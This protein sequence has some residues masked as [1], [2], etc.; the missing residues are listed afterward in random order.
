MKQD[1]VVFP[2]RTNPA[3]AA[4]GA[5]SAPLLVFFGHDSRE[6]TIRKR[7]A[8]FQAEGW[9]VRGFTFARSRVEDEGVPAHSLFWENVHLGQT[10]D[11]NYHRRLAALARAIPSI[12]REAEAIRSA[13]VIYARNLDMMAL[14]VTAKRLCRS[15]AKL[16]YEVLDVQRPLLRSG[17]AG[18]AVRA[19]ER[20]LL[21]QSDLLVVSAPEFV[22]RF[23]KPVQ[24]YSGPVHLLENKIS[25]AQLREAPQAWR[26]G[27]LAPPDDG[28]WIIGWSGVL[29]CA[30]SLQILERIAARMG[31]RVRVVMRGRL[32]EEDLPRDAFET[33]LR[34]QP[35]MSFGGSYRSPDDLATMYGGVHFN[36]SI[37][38]TD[39]GSNSDWLLPNRVYEG[40]FFGVPALARS[41]TASGRF[42]D[43][44]A[45]GHVLPEPL[46]DAVCDLLGRLTRHEY[47][48][49]RRKLL[50]RPESLFVDDGQVA[51]LLSRF[52]AQGAAT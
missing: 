10:Q 44:H 12:L 48:A 40:G 11:R 35:N 18:A 14:A 30:R 21:G 36:W 13:H 6:S 16:V 3:P 27:S 41:E 2:D 1:A 39:A 24:G 43:E 52:S 45:L 32:S 29:R 51:S 7:I 26:R 46:E 49:S 23:F 37:D 22:E 4:R 31:D 25:P 33:L 17:P 38:Y 42:V 9:S 50:E 19:A 28:P 8:S 34:R 5:G 47:S 20:R 15:K